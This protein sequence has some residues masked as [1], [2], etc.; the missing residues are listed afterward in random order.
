MK[1]RAC[2]TLH[3][4]L[5]CG[6][7]AALLTNPAFAHARAQTETTAPTTIAANCTPNKIFPPPTPLT[8]KPCPAKRRADTSIA[9]GIFPQFTIDRS[10]V[11][12]GQFHLQATAPSAGVLGTFSQTFR[13][14]LGYSVHLGYSRVSEN[15]R[16][17]GDAA[18]YDR[19]NF[20]ID[21]NMY[22]SSIS[23]VARTPVNRHFSLFGSAGFGI[24]TFL[25][26]HRGADALVYAPAQDP[27]L[28][29]SAQ[30]R[31]AG[32]PSFGLDFPLT[33][34]LAFRAEY[35]A[36][37]YRDPDFGTDGDYPYTKALTLTSEPTLSLVYNFHTAP[38]PTLHP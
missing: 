20:N 13:P 34:R 15:Y 8:P 11:D 24:L 35:R 3:L 36:L 25:P 38:K 33:R 18:F 26:V 37:I 4:T 17:S 32:I 23:Y 6:I 1:P 27:T 28:I 30:A 10:Q 12:P 22:E 16:N 29:P 14:W 19:N 2:H 5:T 31:P 9:L 7:T 21:T